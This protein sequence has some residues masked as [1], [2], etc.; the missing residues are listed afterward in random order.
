MA[1]DAASGL[2]ER[3]DEL[4]A[5]DAALERAVAGEGG[6]ILLLGPA[7]SGK[8]RLLD[9]LRA[10][11]TDRGV[12]VRAARGG[13][14]EQ[15]LAWGVARDLLAGVAVPGDG[16]GRAA[17]VVLT[18]GAGAAS[19][20]GVLHGLAWVLAD[21]AE[22]EGPLL[23]CVDD[24]HW[25]DAPSLML[26]AHVARRLEGL[27]LTLVLAARPRDPDADRVLLDGLASE[28]G[29][30]IVEPGPLSPAAVASVLGTRLTAAP[31]AELVTACY[32][33]TGGSPLLITELAASSAPG[34]AGCRRRRRARA[35]GG[36]AVRRPPPRAPGRGGRRPGPGR[37][38]PRRRLWPGRGR[39]AGGPGRGARGPARHRAGRQPAAGRRRAA[40]LRPSAPSHGGAGRHRGGR[41]A[42]LARAGRPRAAEA[43]IAAERVALQ[44]LAAEPAADP[45]A[46]A[47]LREAAS[48]ARRQ[49][50][51]AAAA[52]LL[53]RA[54]AEPPPGGERAG[55]LAALAS[56]ELS[57]G[58][59]GAA[60]RVE[61]ALAAL[62]DP[63]IAAALALEA[64]EQLTARLGAESLRPLAVRGLEA[65]ERAHDPEL[66]LRLRAIGALQSRHGPDGDPSAGRE[67]E[68]ELRRDGATTPSGRYALAVAMMAQP[69][70]TPGRAVEA[71]RTI[72]TAWPDGLLPIG[73]A[74]AGVIPLLHA[75]ELDDAFTWLSELEAEQRWR[76]SPAG[77]ARVTT[78]RS[79]ALQLLGDLRGAEADAREAEE[80]VDR[81]SFALTVRT[82]LLVLLDRGEGAAARVEL[83]RRGLEGDLPPGPLHGPVLHARA[84][85]RLGEGDLD[86]ARA[87][88]EALAVRSSATGLD[89]LPYPPW[90]SDLALVLAAQ[91][92][93]HGAGRRA[94][95]ELARAD[96]TWP[97]HSA[98][99]IALRALG[100]VTPGA[101]GIALLEE[102]VAVLERSPRRLELARGLL[103]LGGPAP[104]APA[105]RRARAARARHGPRPPV[106]GRG[107]RRPRAGRAA[108]HGGPPTAAGDRGRRRSHAVR[109][110]GRPAGGTGAH[111]PRDRPGALRDPRD[112]RDPPASR[113][114]EARPRRARRDRR[115][116]GGGR[117]AGGP[118]SQ[119]GTL[120]RDPGA[121]VTV[122][123]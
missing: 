41:A 11:A 89:H 69:V 29:A 25:V 83:A 58:R 7:G 28:P 13:E 37:R 40:A 16:P 15:D 86:G 73:A 36:R 102:A 23:V 103:A 51:P 71:A 52:R 90:R 64:T 87:D 99:G 18:P 94:R 32:A 119:G 111:E 76:T 85:V 3:A 26:L 123:A 112:R 88:L 91:G 14:L 95:E 5:L 22:S 121:R 70:D 78:V 38:H 72:R 20:E 79:V 68:A 33:A 1:P 24:A 84:L 47:V 82:V 61:A 17:A 53:E 100:T 12:G 62:E 39:R 66:V 31:G 67:L 43:G 63:A 118:G 4:A 27:P 54:L 48:A 108:G 10:L 21:L 74:A 113:L 120:M 46:V 81:A 117:H 65:A 35:G 45:E 116:P 30:V 75:D 55:V 9:A 122:A 115:R 57:A 104:R 6:P 50:A 44:V 109:A 107:R 19:A 101:E 2:L 77:V 92:D 93:I 59:A 80:L 56:A 105:R 49:G 8:T 114:P 98:R 60:E 42:P 97:T 34:D 110:A 106:G 96:A